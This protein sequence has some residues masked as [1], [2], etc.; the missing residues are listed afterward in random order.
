MAQFF[1]L[2]PDNPQE[3]L[4]RQAADIIR[5]GGVVVLPTDSCYA[6]VCALGD[7]K[8]MEGIIAIR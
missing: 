1:T 3:R 7:K 2:H 6:L 5:D 8:A 4:V